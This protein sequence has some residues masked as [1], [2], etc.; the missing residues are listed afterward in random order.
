MNPGPGV[1]FWASAGG[2]VSTVWR[3]DRDGVWLYLA[4]GLQVNE[5]RLGLIT[6]Y[7]HFSS[8]IL[9]NA[10]MV[11]QNCDSLFLSTQ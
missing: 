5:F 2:I 8:S 7:F 3:C 10:D 6:K 11:L 4:K 9:N 1:G